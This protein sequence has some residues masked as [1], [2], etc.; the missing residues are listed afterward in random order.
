MMRRLVN[1]IIARASRTPHTHLYHADGSLYMGRFW[2]VR[3][4]WFS[5]RLHHIATPDLDRHFHDHPWTFVSVVLRGGYIEVRP[6]TIEPCFINLPGEPYEI[7]IPNS[8]PAGSI[9]LRRATDRHRVV[10]V[11]PSTWTLVILSPKR[12]WW[13]FYTHKGKV[14]WKDYPSIH[15]SNAQ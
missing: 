1:W 10:A 13:G 4:R 14:H 5:A 3:T 7:G 11:Q 15:K 12:Q 8:R 9:A 2:L 6:A